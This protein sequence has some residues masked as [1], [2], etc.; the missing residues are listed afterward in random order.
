MPTVTQ[1]DA[2]LTLTLDGADYACQITE[3][4][5]TYP[6]TGE[7]TTTPVACG[8]DPVAEPGTP[9][10]GSI[11]GTVYKDTGPNGVTKALIL[12]LESGASLAYEW[13]EGQDADANRLSITGTATVSGHVESFTP[14]LMGKH[15]L[16]LTVVT[17]STAFGPKA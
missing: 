16:A 3:A 11:T 14:D 6:T 12:A 9:V 15:P 1:K 4:E 5:F 17:A 10:N 13:T 7:P 2:R 8:G